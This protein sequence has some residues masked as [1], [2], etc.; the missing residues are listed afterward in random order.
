MI[1]V[2]ITLGCVNLSKVDMIKTSSNFF[3]VLYRGSIGFFFL[4]NHINLHKFTC[5]VLLNKL[6]KGNRSNHILV[7]HLERIKILISSLHRSSSK[8]ILDLWIPM[9]P[10]VMDV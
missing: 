8:I 10:F 5:F 2:L 3:N 6:V 4:N 9:N 1:R 7:I